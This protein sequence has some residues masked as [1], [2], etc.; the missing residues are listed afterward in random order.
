MKVYIPFL[1]LILLGIDW[2]TGYAIAGFV[3]RHGVN[4][5]GYAFWQS[6]G[7]LLLLFVI[8]IFRRDLRI[9]QNGIIY[10]TGC[11]LIGL[12]IPNM[13]MYIASI[14]V[15]SGILTVLANISPILIYP[16]AL[17]LGQ[18]KFAWYR[19]VF[20]I[21]GTMGILILIWPLGHSANLL[22]AKLN[23]W[24][25][26]AL[27]IPLC[28]ATTAVC[29]SRFMPIDG[30][31]LNYAMWMLVMSSIFVTPIMIYHNG[32]YP[33]KTTDFNSWL[34]LLEIFLSTLG[35]VLLFAIIKMAGPV[36]YSLVN[37][38]TAVSGVFYGRMFFGQ[39][40]TL[41]NYCGIYIILVAIIGITILPNKKI[42]K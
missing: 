26:L 6:V 39:Y 24:V 17:L 16:L 37:A 27:L 23:Y 34:I 12:A 13:L 9:A 36:F 1:L 11:G 14:Y 5:Y 2:A 10:A 31:V 20:V 40:F 29:I 7:P 4:P 28:Y 25:Y 3:M 35:Y 19:F 41:W 42:S 32:F 33:L 38:V 30:N 22:F 15:D 8:Q 21:V 18:E